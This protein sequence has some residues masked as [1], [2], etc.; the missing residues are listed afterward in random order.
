MAPLDNVISVE[1]SRSGFWEVLT[2]MP[3]IIGDIMVDTLFLSPNLNN[4]G[5]GLALSHAMYPLPRGPTKSIL[6]TSVHSRM[7]LGRTRWTADDLGA[8]AQRWVLSMTERL[9][10]LSWKMLTPIARRTSPALSAT[11]V[12]GFFSSAPRGLKYSTSSTARVAKGG[13][14]I[15][16]PGGV[17]EEHGPVGS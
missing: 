14:G 15:G 12:I 13:E 10:V 7:H 16:T 8:A 6:V 5:V 4:A 2:K 9:D 3:Q 17:R 11:Y 1:L